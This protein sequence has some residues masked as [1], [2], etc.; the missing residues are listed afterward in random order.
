MNILHGNLWNHLGEYDALCI[1]TNGFVKKN[2]EVVMGAG[3]AKQ[4]RDR[5]KGLAHTLGNYIRLRGNEPH[6][7]I[8][9]HWT[10]EIPYIISFPVK[11]NWNE[12]ADLTLIKMSAMHL[13]CILDEYELEKVALPAPGVGNGKRDWETEV[14]PIIQRVFG[15]DDRVDIWFYK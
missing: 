9:A 5:Y 15:D 1:T 14:K 10:D 8:M 6:V 12:E 3:I 2:G 11:H 7:L 4:A 13:S